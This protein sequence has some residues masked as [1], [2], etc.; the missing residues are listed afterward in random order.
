MLKQYF[1]MLPVPKIP[2]AITTRG[3]SKPVPTKVL[4]FRESKNS[5]KPNEILGIN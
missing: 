3:N 5:K 2:T 1:E 4:C